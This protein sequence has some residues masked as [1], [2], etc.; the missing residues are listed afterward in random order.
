VPG[1]LVADVTATIAPPRTLPASL[2]GD[3][4]DLCM[5][6]ELIKH[7]RCNLPGIDGLAKHGL[8]HRRD[9]ETTRNQPMFMYSNKLF[10]PHSWYQSKRTHGESGSQSALQALHFVVELIKG[11]AKLLCELRRPASIRR[12]REVD[13][14]SVQI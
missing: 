5:V 4:S 8:M 1:A 10:V 14:K 3:T 6:R 7:Q 11:Q 12:L 2:R 13:L 9:L